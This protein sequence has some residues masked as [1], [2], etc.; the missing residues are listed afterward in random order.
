MFY[1]VLFFTVGNFRKRLSRGGTL[2]CLCLEQHLC[3]QFVRQKAGH[4]WKAVV[5]KD[6]K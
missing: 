5:I 2:S 4:Y 1:F 6:E 3:W